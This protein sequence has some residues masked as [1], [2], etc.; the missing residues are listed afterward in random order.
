MLAT[1]D[2]LKFWAAVG[3]VA[4]ASVALFKLISLSKAGEKV[5]A[6]RQLADFI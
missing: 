3:M 2:E 5:P 6:L 1:I 4:V